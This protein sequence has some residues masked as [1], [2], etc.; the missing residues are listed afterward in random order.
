MA[1]SRYWKNPEERGG[2]KKILGYLK[3]KKKQ[4]W[5]GSGGTIK[6]WKNYEVLKN[7]D[8]LK[9]NPED[10]GSQ[11]TAKTPAKLIKDLETLIIKKN[12]YP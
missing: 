3:K 12:F 4:K 2:S 9:K 1:I 6:P 10:W 5:W 11:S 7:M 8:I